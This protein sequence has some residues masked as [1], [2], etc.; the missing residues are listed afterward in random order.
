[1][2]RRQPGEYAP[3]PK[4]VTESL[5]ETVTTRGSQVVGSETGDVPLP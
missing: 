4:V 5:G 1:M 2:A 3:H